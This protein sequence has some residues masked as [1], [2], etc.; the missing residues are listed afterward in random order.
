LLTLTQTQQDESDIQTQRL[1]HKT[2]T[3]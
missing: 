2:E 3:Y 1:N